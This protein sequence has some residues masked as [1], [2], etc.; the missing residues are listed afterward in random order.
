M[1]FGGH[2]VTMSLRRSLGHVQKGRIHI[3]VL[4]DESGLVGP[5]K[6]K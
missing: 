3:L 1:E 4:I 6:A 2:G 5:V